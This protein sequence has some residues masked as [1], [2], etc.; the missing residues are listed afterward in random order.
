MARGDTTKNT[1]AGH[2]PQVLPRDLEDSR[3]LSLSTMVLEIKIFGCF[4]SP[5]YVEELDVAFSSLSISEKTANYE[6]TL[7]PSL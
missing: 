2:S 5:A 6:P 7:F 3:S 4:S 1:V